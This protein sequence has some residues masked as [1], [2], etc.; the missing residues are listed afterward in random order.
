MNNSVNLN[1]TLITF[2][3][4]VDD[5]DRLKK[6]DLELQSEINEVRSWFSDTKS[7]RSVK[8]TITEVEIEQVRNELSEASITLEKKRWEYWKKLTA[9]E[10]EIKDIGSVF[11]GGKDEDKKFWVKVR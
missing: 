1:D 8:T 4:W 6:R 9:I 5:L 3:S 10:N 2:K 7:N 11:K